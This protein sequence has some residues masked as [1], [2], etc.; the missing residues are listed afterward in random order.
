[1]RHH[2][3]FRGWDSASRA[4][5]IAAAAADEAAARAAPRFPDWHQPLCGCWRS[6]LLTLGVLLAPPV[7]HGCAAAALQQRGFFGGVK[8]AVCCLAWTA[9]CCCYGAPLAETRMLLRTNYGIGV[10]IG[11]RV[12]REMRKQDSQDV[13]C[14]PLLT[15]AQEAAELRRQRHLAAAATQQQGELEPAASRTQAPPQAAMTRAAAGA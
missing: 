1:M 13:C 14:C 7:A 4:G 8:E 11:G 12:R 5:A 2:R 3:Q 10:P 9:C 6:P 15:L